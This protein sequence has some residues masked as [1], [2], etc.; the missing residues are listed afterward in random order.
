MVLGDP[1]V[2]AVR[3]SG[4]YPRVLWGGRVAVLGMAIFLTAVFFINDGVGLAITLL[5]FLVFVVGYLVMMV[6]TAKVA[7]EH[8]GSVG[9]F[10]R[11]SAIAAIQLD[12]FRRKPPIRRR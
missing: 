2:E 5:S 3:R 11:A 6:A 12:L 4:Y 10:V 7:D 9:R 1:G 8:P